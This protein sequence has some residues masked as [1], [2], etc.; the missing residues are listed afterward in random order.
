LRFSLDTQRIFLLIDGEYVGEMLFFEDGEALEVDISDLSTGTHQLKAV[1]ISTAGRV[2]CSNIKDST[3]T[4]FLNHC[5]CADAYDSNEPHY[6]CAYYSG[7]ENV[8]VKV[9]DEDNSIVWSQTYTGQN[10]HGFIPAEI[11]L[12]DDLDSLVFEETSAGGGSAGATAAGASVTKALG[13]KFKP[14]KVPANI[15]A[16]II[17]PSRWMRWFG[18]YG[19]IQA[20]KSGFKTRG[21]PY[22]YL[23]GS[24]ASYANLAWYG[25]NRNI[26]YIYYCHHSGYEFDGVLRSKIAL[27][28]GIAVSVKQSDFAPGQAPSW[29]EKLPGSLEK[30]AN[31]MFLTGFSQGE[32]KFVHF[33]CCCTGRLKLSGS[34]LVEGQPGQQGLF[35][36]PHSD[37]SW[38]LRMSS[39]QTQVF[40]GWWGE[41]KKGE[42][43]KFNHFAYHEWTKLGEGDNLYNA[44]MYAINET[45]WIP[46]GPHDNYRVKGQGDLTDLRIE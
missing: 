7:A 15:R 10:L 16:L 40:Q 22:R 19:V 13:L 44:L 45:D 3:F 28:D 23:K 29:C 37:M 12:A 43:S 33:D 30:T 31:S 17:V 1:S 11:T 42:T 4:C 32:L 25:V 20:V 27:S 18:D 46:D 35:D 6:F 9:Y 26:N 24:Q 2:T 36:L 14:K 34:K 41:F 38:A 8:S 21:V 5:F 39:S